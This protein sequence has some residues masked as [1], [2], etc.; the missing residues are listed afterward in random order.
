MHPSSH[1][2]PTLDPVSLEPSSPESA[3]RS[4]LEALQNQEEV[5]ARWLEVAHAFRAA[6]QPIQ[7]IEACEACIKL[8]E[9]ETEAWFLIADL[10]LAVGHRDIAG[11]ALS[12]I[13]ELAPDDERTTDLA[14]RI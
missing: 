3:L 14:A 1:P 12:V 2:L 7:A 9:R 6:G 10:A 13:R 4:A 8:N 11:E 5:P